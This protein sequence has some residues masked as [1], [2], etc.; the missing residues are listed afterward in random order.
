MLLDIKLNKNQLLYVIAYKI[1]IKSISLIAI[2]DISMKFAG[3]IK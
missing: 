2:C 3:L 1:N